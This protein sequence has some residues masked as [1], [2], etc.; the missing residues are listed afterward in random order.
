MRYAGR[1]KSKR[2]NSEEDEIMKTFIENYNGAK[3]YWVGYGY[4]A[5]CFTHPKC[6]WPNEFD[7]KQDAMAA[8]DKLVSK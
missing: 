4:N 2:T 1:L 6:D 7:S 8:V 5:V 3:L